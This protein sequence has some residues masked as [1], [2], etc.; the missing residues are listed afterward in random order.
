MMSVEFW[1]LLGL[2]VLS[3]VV[4]VTALI[5]V[6]NRQ[7]GQGHIICGLQE[8][9]GRHGRRVM[10]SRDHRTIIQNLAGEIEA[11]AELNKAAA[12]GAFWKTAG[13]HILRIRDM[14]DGHL[15][16]CLDGFAKGEVADK[17]VE[18]LRRRAV[19]KSLRKADL[20]MAEPKNAWDPERDRLKQIRHALV[21]DHETQPDRTLRSFV[22]H[23]RG[24]GLLA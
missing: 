17:M 20:K 5:G 9:V 4:I 7:D 8:D 24:V 12:G 3:V 23:L 18:E 15:N 11:V 1:V 19:D 16:N 6:R 21:K 14:S 22:E 10:E 2:M 13:G